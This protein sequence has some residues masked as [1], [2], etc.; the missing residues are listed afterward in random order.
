MSF[1]CGKCNKAQPPKTSSILCVIKTRSKIY[2]NEAG[3]ETGRGTETVKAIRIC[4][5][6]DDKIKKEKTVQLE[7]E[8]CTLNNCIHA[9]KVK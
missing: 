7:P 9:P 8:K 6:C 3:E 5:K 2:T 4:K 1:R